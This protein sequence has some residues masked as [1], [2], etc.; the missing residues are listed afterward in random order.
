MNE[1]YGIS[2]A[3]AQAIY[4]DSKNSFADQLTEITDGDCHKGMVAGDPGRQ[5]T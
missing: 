3:K 1:S 4:E 5:L 2:K